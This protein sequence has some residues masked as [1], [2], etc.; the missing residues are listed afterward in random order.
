MQDRLRAAR[1]PTA[2]TDRD[3]AS[4]AWGAALPERGETTSGEAVDLPPDTLARHRV[5]ELIAHGVAYNHGAWTDEARRFG[6]HQRYTLSEAWNSET[7]FGAVLAT[8]TPQTPEPPVLAFV[9]SDDTFDWLADLDPTTPAGAAQFADAET[10]VLDLVANGVDGCVYTGHSLGGCLAQVAAV[11]AR[12][13]GRS[14]P[15]VVTFNAPGIP[16]E[17]VAAFARARRAPGE[18]PEVTH[19]TRAEDPVSRAG[20]A[21]LPGTY[22]K[23]GTGSIRRQ[24]DILAAH[25]RCFLAGSPGEVPQVVGDTAQVTAHDP[26]GRDRQA[27]GVARKMLGTLV[28][29]VM[30]RLGID[31]PSQSLEHMAKIVAARGVRLVLEHPVDFLDL[32]REVAERLAEVLEQL[33]ALRDPALAHTLRTAVQAHR[34]S[35]E[36][37]LGSLESQAGARR[38]TACE[39]AL[40]RFRAATFARLGLDDPGGVLGGDSDTGRWREDWERAADHVRPWTYEHF[41]RNGRVVRRRGGREVDELAVVLARFEALQESPDLDGGDGVAPEDGIDG[42]GGVI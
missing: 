11:V 10:A 5:I 9:G 27:V 15:E 7:G 38:R 41:V 1:S 39:A 25:T 26:D 36:S 19:Y 33:G 29:V 4:A 20:E 18:H 30:E 21:A 34:A 22:V 2:S 14:V 13:H 35:L 37:T 24:G 23:V 8:P 42:E 40:E 17:R 3:G 16:A 31:E 28:K 32:R 12:L 6:L